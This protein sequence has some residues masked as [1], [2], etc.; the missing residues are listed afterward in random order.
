MEIEGQFALREILFVLQ[1]NL[2]TRDRLRTIYLTHQ[3]FAIPSTSFG[4]LEAYNFL[5]GEKIYCSMTDTLQLVI[6]L[7]N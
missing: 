3:I 6:I 5:S 7:R 1:K 4:A 2:S